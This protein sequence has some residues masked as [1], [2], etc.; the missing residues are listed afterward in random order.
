MISKKNERE[1]WNTSVWMT[2][3]PDRKIRCQGGHFDEETRHWRYVVNVKNTSG[4]IFVSSGRELTS[5]NRCKRRMRERW[6]DL[7]GSEQKQETETT[8]ANAQSWYIV[9][10]R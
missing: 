8:A 4:M 6:N 5:N 1:A 10:R 3:P 7:M 9:F 2:R